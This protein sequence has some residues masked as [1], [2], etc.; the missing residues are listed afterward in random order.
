MIGVGFINIFI[1]ETVAIA[2]IYGPVVYFGLLKEL[3]PIFS[4]AAVFHGIVHITYPF[5]NG[6]T[7]FDF[8]IDQSVDMISHSSMLFVWYYQV[9]Y[10][11]NNKT[12]I[13]N[14]SLI[15]T[16]FKWLLIG[17]IGCYIATLYIHSREYGWAL[18]I[19]GTCCLNLSPALCSAL[20]VGHMLVEA[21]Y[22]CNEKS[23][24]NIYIVSIV[25]TVFAFAILRGAWQFGQEV[26]NDTFAIYGMTRFFQSFHCLAVFLAQISCYY[27]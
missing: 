11:S 20:F 5:I 2:I 18:F 3:Y 24:K 10:K 16:L 22:P 14:R 7:G 1:N 9:V 12:F 26:F 6:T 4:V 8:S 17:N 21:R 13:E 19:Y 25:S 23:I 15:K 27:R